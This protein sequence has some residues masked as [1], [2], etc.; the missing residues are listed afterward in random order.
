MYQE[1]K[2][3]VKEDIKLISSQ[4]C[5]ETA[6]SV[7]VFTPKL[8]LSLTNSHLILSHLENLRK[9]SP[10]PYDVSALSL[11]LFIYECVNGRGHTNHVTR[12][13]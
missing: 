6:I 2:N 3:K 8:S 13:P 11:S 1:D 4:F 10:C 9:L 7:P 12:R 5:C